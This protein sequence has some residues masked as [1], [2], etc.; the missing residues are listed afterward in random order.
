[1]VSK[2]HLAYQLWAFGS[3]IR[4][5]MVAGMSG[6]VFDGSRLEWMFGETG[7]RLKDQGITWFAHK[8]DAEAALQKIADAYIGLKVKDD[9]LVLPEGVKFE[10]AIAAANPGWSDVPHAERYR[11]LSA[12][13]KGAMIRL[14]FADSDS[15]GYISAYYVDAHTLSIKLYRTRPDALT[16]KPELSFIQKGRMKSGVTKDEKFLSIVM[17]ACEKALG[18]DDLDMS[19]WFVDVDFEKTVESDKEFD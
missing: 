6:F 5:G 10:D 13:E 1:M 9:V 4:V 18:V 12:P 15:I 11:N 7:L 17:D 14:N 19:D 2:R 8:S 16:D 3:G